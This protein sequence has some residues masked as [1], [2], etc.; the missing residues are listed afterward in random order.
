V[1]TRT[2]EEHAP[3]RLLEKLLWSVS[4]AEFPEANIPRSSRPAFQALP[5]KVN[6]RVNPDTLEYTHNKHTTHT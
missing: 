6:T 5:C 3:A 2:R 1:G 4:I